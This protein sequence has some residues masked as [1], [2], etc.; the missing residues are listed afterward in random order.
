[1]TPHKRCHISTTNNGVISTYTN[2]TIAYGLNGRNQPDDLAY[3]A[4]W[5]SKRSH[6][7]THHGHSPTHHGHS[8][9]HHGHSPTHHGHSTTHHGHS[10]THHGHNPTVANYGIQT[11]QTFGPFRKPFKIKSANLRFEYPESLLTNIISLIQ[12]K[13]MLQAS[14]F[15]VTFS[16]WFRWIFKRISTNKRH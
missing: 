13:P 14:H 4:Q 7:S 10:T 16:V 15:L 9:T 3:L 5:P 11:S 2:I 8:P 12:A 6:S 1:M